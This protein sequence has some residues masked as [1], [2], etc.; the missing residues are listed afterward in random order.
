MVMATARVAELTTGYE[1]R[2]S[3]LWVHRGKADVATLRVTNNLTG[4]GAGAGMELGHQT[5][6]TGYGF[7]QAYDR[8]LN[9]WRDLYLSGKNVTIQATGGTLNL[10]AN[11][12]GS[13]QIADGSIQTADIAPN[14]VQQLLGQYVGAPTWSTTTQN[15]LA[16]PLTC[17]ITTGGGY[18]RFE[19][20]FTASHSAAN[21]TWFLGFGWDGAVSIGLTSVVAPA[22]GNVISSTLIYYGALSAGTHTVTTYVYMITAGTLTIYTGINSVLFVTEQKR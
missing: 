3:G 4:P 18:L 19:S 7:I 21:A 14:A 12:V 13:S 16:T 1:Q 10:P 22:V 9:A 6:P 11:S 17:S 2:T 15:W 5:G 8:D 20:T